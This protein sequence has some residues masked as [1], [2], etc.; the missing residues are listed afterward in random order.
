MSGEKPASL[1]PTPVLET[2][3]LI[4]RPLRASD[5]PT[6]QRRFP[7]W[8][9]VRFLSA[10]VPWPYPSNGAEANTARALGE[11]ERSEKLHWAI[12]LKGGPDELIGVI[13]LWPE[14]GMRT[15]RGFWLDPEYWGR[16]L[17]TEAADRVTEYAFTEL[18]WSELY[19]C[20]AET[21][22]ASHR[23]KEKQ[24]ARIIDRIP[25]TY[26]SG[27]GTKIVWLLKRQDW[28]KRR[29]MSHVG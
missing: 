26:V 15:Q 11:M 16:G 7:Q 22:L 14:T 20:N 10:V 1:P 29:G 18:A 23:V 5:A 12:T 9:V 8:P 2:P 17:M 3:R 19:L 4:L 21:N 24:G 6:I 25:A 28:L 13:D 27:P